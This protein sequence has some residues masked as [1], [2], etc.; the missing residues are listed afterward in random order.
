MYVCAVNHI[1]ILLCF[2]SLPKK[3]L[4]ANSK[5]QSLTVA[6]MGIIVAETPSTTTPRSKELISSIDPLE[7]GEGSDDSC[8]E[9][10]FYPLDNDYLVAKIDYNQAIGQPDPDDVTGFVTGPKEWVE[11]M[12]QEMQKTRPL[13][14]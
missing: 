4:L 9:E 13:P 5:E 6:Q 11:N 12:T 10:T 1:V 8:D 14:P 3:G 7:A 2:Y